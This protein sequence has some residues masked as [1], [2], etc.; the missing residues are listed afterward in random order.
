MRLNREVMKELNIMATGAWI[1]V[2]GFVVECKPAR[3]GDGTIGFE[4]S[5]VFDPSVTGTL[6]AKKCL[7][8]LLSTQTTRRRKGP[9]FG[10]N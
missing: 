2:H 7:G 5:I 1:H 6:D 4:V 8:R 10:L 9:L 3:R